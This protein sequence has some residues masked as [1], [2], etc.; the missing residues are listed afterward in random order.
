MCRGLMVR[1]AR[2]LQQLS[3]MKH[4]AHLVLCGDSVQHLPSPLLQAGQL[5]HLTLW[6]R[7]EF[8]AS[9]LSTLQPGMFRSLHSL[10]IEGLLVSHTPEQQSA[11]LEWV[12]SLL[13]LRELKCADNGITT[14]PAGLSQLTR[15]QVSHQHYHECICWKLLATAV[16][17]NN[18]RGQGTL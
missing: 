1:C 9:N 3:H 6:P 14:L 15:L 4:L 12:G 7:S 11:V 18:V 2:Q 13:D 10:N 16:Q 8:E 5:T 17:C